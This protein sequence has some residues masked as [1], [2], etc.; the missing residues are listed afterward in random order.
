MWYTPTISEFG[1][2]T[3]SADP[4]GAHRNIAIAK[5]LRKLYARAGLPY[6]S[7]HK[8]RHGHAVY[9]L[10]HAQT[11]ADYKAASMNL[12]HSD[13]RTTDS[14]YAPLAS[15]EVQRRIAALTGPPTE[16]QGTYATSVNAFEDLTDAQLSQVMAVAAKRLVR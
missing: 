2:Q 6:Q 11:M 3:L 12:M 5:R 13:I 8:F 1:Q 10:Q 14:I 7:P 4:P 15:D 16:Q 9:A